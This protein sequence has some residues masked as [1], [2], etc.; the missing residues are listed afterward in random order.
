MGELTPEVGIIRE[1]SP[2]GGYIL[3]PFIF[4]YN[5]EFILKRVASKKKHCM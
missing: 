4:N 5:R 1:N 2:T 3:S